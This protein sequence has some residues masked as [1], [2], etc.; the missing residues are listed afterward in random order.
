MDHRDAQSATVMNRVSNSD[1]LAFD[2]H[3]DKNG[4]ITI[5]RETKKNWI[6]LFLATSPCAHTTIFLTLITLK[7]M[8]QFLPFQA[9]VG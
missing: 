7:Y 9:V 1:T 3:S 8:D 6:F 4:N 2:S 5:L